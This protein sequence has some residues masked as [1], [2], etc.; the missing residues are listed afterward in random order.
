V[1]TGQGKRCILM[2]DDN[3]LLLSATAR[4]VRG[5]GH[6][7]VTANRIAEAKAVA[8]QIQPGVVITDLRFSA[9]S[10]LDLLEWIKTRW[11]EVP[12]FIYT[13]LE[14]WRLAALCGRL[15]ASDYFVKLRDDDAMHRAIDGTVEFIR[16]GDPGDLGKHVASS[17][18]AQRTHVL[19]VLE[20]CNGNIS[21]TARLLDVARPTLQ[22]WLREYGIAPRPQGR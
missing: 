5:R 7:V 3:D 14:S 8:S 19:A 9:Q 21:E 17:D 12:V 15:G 6:E 2:V 13:G 11:R 1:R 20:L 22:R 16:A 10:G 4:L 18:A